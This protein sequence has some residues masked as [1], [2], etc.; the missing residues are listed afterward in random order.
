MSNLTPGLMFSYSSSLP[1]EG[2]QRR[3][4]FSAQAGA[5]GG[6][7]EDSAHTCQGLAQH[8]APGE[9]GVG[10]EAEQQ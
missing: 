5:G 3:Q 4:P 8:N 6:G 9:L 10:P 7:S 2:G 1:D